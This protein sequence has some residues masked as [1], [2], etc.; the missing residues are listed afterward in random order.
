ME[1]VKLSKN[2]T[3]KLKIKI[4]INKEEGE[5]TQEI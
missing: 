2:E 4:W 5:T 1:K 3:T